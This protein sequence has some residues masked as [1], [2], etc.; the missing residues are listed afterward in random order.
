MNI[1]KTKQGLKIR[2]QKFKKFLYEIF[3]STDNFRQHLL[4]ASDLQ[5]KTLTDFLQGIFS[6]SINLP[7]NAQKFFEIYDTAAE[8]Y[9]KYFY[10]QSEYRKFLKFD[11]QKRIRILSNKFFHNLVKEILSTLFIDFD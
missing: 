11:R 4:K 9:G 8:F 2:I 10:L 6:R 1:D 5:L 7:P 3:S